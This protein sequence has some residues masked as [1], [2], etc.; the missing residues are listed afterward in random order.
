MKT[1]RTA[2]IA[3]MAGIHPNTVRFY[4]EQGLLPP[5]PR[6]DNGYRIFSETHL[7]QL[8]LIRRAFKAEILNSN[9]RDEAVAIVKT[10]AAGNPDDAVHKTTQYQAHIRGEIANAREAVR[11]TGE[12]LTGEHGSGKD[13]P[14]LGRREA[15][16][17]I[18]VTM[19][20]LRDWERNGL[21]SVLRKGNRRQYGTEETNRLLIIS[22]LRNAGYSQMAI[23]RMLVQVTQGETDLLLALNTPEETE[24]IISVADRYITS[25][26]GALEDTN[27]MLRILGSMKQKK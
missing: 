4:E 26:S 18:G 7:L 16:A 19:E 13:T 25:L 15:A 22:V 5:V 1:F 12:L 17:L 2:E 24:D 23:R 20:V 21:V 8:R 11:I 9:L 14:P 27:G 6:M 3:A 10:A